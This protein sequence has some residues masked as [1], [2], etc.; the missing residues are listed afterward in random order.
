MSARD[1]L[2][3]DSAEL[4]AIQVVEGDEREVTNVVATLRRLAAC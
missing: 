3:Q 2:D 1:Q 4:R